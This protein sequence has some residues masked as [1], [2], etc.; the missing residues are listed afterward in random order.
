MTYLFTECNESRLC[1]FSRVRAELWSRIGPSARIPELN[2][3]L[4]NTRT[5]RSPDGHTNEKQMAPCSDGAA[6]V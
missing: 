1:V 4:R 6:R 5:Y 3:Y 2:T